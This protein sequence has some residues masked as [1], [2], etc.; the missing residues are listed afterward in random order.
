MKLPTLLSNFSTLQIQILVQLWH[1]K[2]DCSGDMS[3]LSTMTESFLRARAPADA[4]T[5]AALQV[6]AGPL[7]TLLYVP[8]HRPIL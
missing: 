8:G 1:S 3:A 2:S 6:L 4:G 5:T 7:E